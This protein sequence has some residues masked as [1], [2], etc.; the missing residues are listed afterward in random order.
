MPR[1]LR[2]SGKSE[3]RNSPAG[4][5]LRL[6]PSY[7]IGVSFEGSRVV[8]GEGEMLGWLRGCGHQAHP[9]RRLETVPRPL[10]D[11]H[12]HAGFER[13]GL[14]S[15]VRHDVEGHRAVDDLHALVAVWMSLPRTFGGEFGDVD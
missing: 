15:V 3:S 9:V 1:A 5:A 13:M 14:R 6:R 7:D 11:D 12:D 8:D 10:R 4:D 2:L